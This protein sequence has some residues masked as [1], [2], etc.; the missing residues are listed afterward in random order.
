[1]KGFYPGLM[2]LESKCPESALYFPYKEPPEQFGNHLIKKLILRWGEG[3]KEN[4][5]TIKQ[6]PSRVKQGGVDTGAHWGNS[7]SSAVCLKIFIIKRL[8]EWTQF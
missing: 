4:R 5:A 7:F 1:M 8:V 3:W 2:N 6:V